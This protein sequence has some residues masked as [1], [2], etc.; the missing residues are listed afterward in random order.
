[1]QKSDYSADVVIVGAGISGALMA[2]GLAKANAKVLIIEAGDRIDRSKA[3]E[4]Y[5]ADPERGD[6]SPYNPVSR[7]APY[8]PMDDPQ[9]YYIQMGPDKFQ[10]TYI[11]AVGGTT[12]HWLGTCL[13][14][15]ENDFKMKTEYGVGTDWPITYK[16]IE[17]WYFA[18]EQEIPVSGD[19]NA[20]LGVKR[21][22]PYPSAMIPQTYLDKQVDIAFQN[23]NLP[24]ATDIKLQVA[25][26]PQGRLSA[27]QDERLACCGSNNCIPICPVGAK[28]DASFTIA[29]AEALGVKVL[30][31]S[32]AKFI[33]TDDEGSVTGILFQTADG[34][35]IAAGKIF[36]LAGHAIETPKLMLMSKTE[37][38]P[39]GIANSSDQVGRNLMDHN[40]VLSYG[41]TKDPVYPY[42]AP[43]S[44]SGVENV[45]DGPFRK[46][47]GAFRI[48]IGNDGWSWPVGY[49]NVLSSYFLKKS[50]GRSSV[51]NL[52]AADEVIKQGQ[53]NLLYGKKLRNDIKEN[54]LREIRFAFLC[55]QLP[56]PNNRIVP[57]FDSLGTDGLP[58]PRI[59]YKLDDYVKASIDVAVTLQKSMLDSLGCTQQHHSYPWGAGHIVGTTKMGDD[60]KTSVVDKNLKCH[61]LKNMYILG[62]SVFPTVA[63]SNP[64]LTI[65]ALTLRAV[66]E[67]QKKLLELN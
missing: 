27:P 34:D 42:Q 29:K 2:L 12:W 49:P 55:E 64:T 17:K 33:Q 4:K 8:P 45:K 5:K 21:E 13:R 32:T 11:K 58:R 56:D 30:T 63:A 18:A 15:V 19:S 10:S 14:F 35:K 52:P 31:N 61:D 53:N 46:E 44:T 24:D 26:T 48:E 51:M 54:V 43:L 65:A 22:K 66:E 3:I 47:R 62:S 50:G 59:F 39:N 67:I 57:A 25:S 36:I 16:E 28:Y 41:L 23:L 9:Q 20:A 6:D 1:M 37:K 40:C 38:Y 7:T 60:P